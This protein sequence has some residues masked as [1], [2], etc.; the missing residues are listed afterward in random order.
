MKK[1]DKSQRS[2]WRYY[3][4]HWAAFQMVAV[5]LGV[6]RPRHL[7]HDWYK[8][9]LKMF[10]IP[11]SEIQYIHRHSSRHHLEYLELNNE[12]RFDWDSM[13]VDWEC[14]QYTKEACKRN[15]RQKLEHILNDYPNDEHNTYIKYLLR[16][17]VEPR[18]EKLGL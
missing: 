1:F 13:I 18:L 5:M 12:T 3:W 2:G 11:Y 10:G 14:S 4:A 15:A 17:Y 6:W 7:F 8:P 9:W 16:R